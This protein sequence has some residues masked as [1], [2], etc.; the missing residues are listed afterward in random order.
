MP[1]PNSSINNF[2]LISLQI[3]TKSTLPWL[4]E[5]QKSN[6]N[7]IKSRIEGFM[8]K[9]S[10]NRP[11][12]RLPHPSLPTNERNQR[13]LAIR[14]AI[15]EMTET[16]NAIMAIPI[17]VCSYSFLLSLQIVE[18]ATLT[19]PILGSISLFL[20]SNHSG[21][22]TVRIE[23]DER[24]KIQSVGFGFGK[25]L[26]SYRLMIPALST[27]SPFQRWFIPSQD[28]STNHRLPILSQ[29]ASQTAEAYRI[30][31][32]SSYRPGTGA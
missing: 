27:D 28:C 21:I 7:R 15:V 9:S 26:T 32:E 24:I 1:S 29:R 10:Q 16:P 12:G 2:L 31:E 6:Q 25:A 13:K 5:Y 11:S 30:L 20:F 23:T 14:L 18:Y 19:F 8:D 17:V 4:D 3:Y 22:E